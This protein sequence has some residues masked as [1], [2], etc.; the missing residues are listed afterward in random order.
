MEPG[1]NGPLS[2]RFHVIMGKWFHGT[3]EHGN[4]GSGLPWFTQAMGESWWWPPGGR[5]W[6]WRTEPHA[7]GAFDHGIMDRPI[8]CLMV[9]LNHGS[10]K[11]DPS[12]LGGRM[13]WNP[14][15]MGA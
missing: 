8:L 7:V 12:Y 5:R 10:M 3:S 13:S 14:A 4:H 15:S 9:P 2:P 11:L 6:R 1:N